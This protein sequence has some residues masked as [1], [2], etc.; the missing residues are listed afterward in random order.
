MQASAEPEAVTLKLCP[1]GT[2]VA[3]VNDVLDAVTVMLPVPLF[4]SVAES[5][6]VSPE[7]VPPTVYEL[8]THVIVTEVTF[9]VP[10]VPDGRCA[11]SLDVVHFCETGTSG[12]AP[13]VTL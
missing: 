6:P 3:K 5:P 10:T 7:I 12:L 11:G 8:V 1:L 2:G 4:C 13:I 9:V